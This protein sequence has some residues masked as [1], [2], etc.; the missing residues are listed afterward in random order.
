MTGV[1]YSGLIREALQEFIDEP[2]VAPVLSR[3]AEQ[4]TFLYG[5]EIPLS[6]V[7]RALS[8]LAKKPARDIGKYVPERGDSR[9]KLHYSEETVAAYDYFL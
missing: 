3:T 1:H 8:G 6:A 9:A 5:D 2:E 4:V 7:E